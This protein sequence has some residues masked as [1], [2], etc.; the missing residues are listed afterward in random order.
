MP[1]WQPPV[2]SDAASDQTVDSLRVFGIDR[3]RR[4]L[5]PEMS[6]FDVE[7]LRDQCY[8]LA[9]TVVRALNETIAQHRS[10]A[11]EKPTSENYPAC[12]TDLLPG[13]YEGAGR[14]LQSGYE[15]EA[16]H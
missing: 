13:Q 12:C 10:K 7:R 15:G 1:N 11:R 9:D 4:F 2:D 3:C 6:D 16:M 8:L 14:E 5:R